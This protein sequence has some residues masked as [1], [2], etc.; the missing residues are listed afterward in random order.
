MGKERIQTDLACPRFKT[1]IQD[2]QIPKWCL[3]Y[4]HWNLHFPGEIKFGKAEPEQ[5][6]HDS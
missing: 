1:C 6:Y 3:V 4:H 2:E 5:E